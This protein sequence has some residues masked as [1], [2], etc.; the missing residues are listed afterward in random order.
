MLTPLMTPLFLP[1]PSLFTD[2]FGG[3]VPRAYMSAPILV[4]Y[5]NNWAGIWPPSICK[6][7]F[8]EQIDIPRGKLFVWTSKIYRV[9]A[10]IH[11]Q[12]LD[13]P[14]SKN[15]LNRVRSKRLIVYAQSIAPHFSPQSSVFQDRSEVEWEKSGRGY[16]TSQNCRPS[17]LHIRSYVET[18]T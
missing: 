18:K 17:H 9:T 15:C 7:L 8:V 1:L 16:T 6:V 14:L 5:C 2:L 12:Y 13:T 4:N 10:E 11:L 3:S